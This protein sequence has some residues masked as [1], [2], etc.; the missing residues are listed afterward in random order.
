M[1]NKYHH[2]GEMSAYCFSLTSCYYIKHYWKLG[3][4]AVG[5]IFACVCESQGST[6][7]IG[8]LVI[9]HFLN[10]CLFQI[11]RFEYQVC[12]SCHILFRNFASLCWYPTWKFQISI[13]VVLFF[14]VSS[15]INIE[16]TAC[17]TTPYVCFQQSDPFLKILCNMMANDRLTSWKYLHESDFS[18]VL[19][20][21]IFSYYWIEEM[22][23]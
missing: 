14:S 4:P 17:N 20:H 8:A 3:K 9:K 16:H 15:F 1:I 18:N 10:T 5:N 7:W 21:D 6:R 11:R 23:S 12:M 22:D 19:R 2:H 13:S